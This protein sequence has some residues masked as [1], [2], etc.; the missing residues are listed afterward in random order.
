MPSKS[1]SKAL[2][3]FVNTEFLLFLF[4]LNGTL[5]L[6]NFH[7]I[8]RDILKYHYRENIC[9]IYTDDLISK[10]REY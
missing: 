4:S 3:Y 6:R 10:H 1:L 7:V 2:K 8:K 5:S 9:R